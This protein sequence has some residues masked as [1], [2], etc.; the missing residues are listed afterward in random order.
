MEKVLFS[1]GANGGI[2]DSNM[3][4]LEGSERFTDVSGLVGHKISQ[5]LI[6]TAQTL[7]PA[8][9]GDAISTLHQMARLGKGKSTLSCIQMEAF[10]D[11]INDQTQLIS[12]GNKLY[13]WIVNTCH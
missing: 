10:G 6:V 5:L 3:R 8:H 7:V 11:D 12:V 13:W 1:C 2:C 4:V 9:K